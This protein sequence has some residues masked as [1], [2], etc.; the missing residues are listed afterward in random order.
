MR[1]YTQRFCH[2]LH[3]I[4]DISPAAIIAAFHANVRDPKMREKLSTRTVRSTAEL[5][6]LADKCARAEEGRLVPG[7]TLDGVEKPGKKS[8]KLQP[9][10]QALAVEPTAKKPKAAVAAAGKAG[11]PWCSIHNSTGHDLKD[12]RE[13]QSMAE[14][15]Q[16]AWKGAKK[17]GQGGE[18]EGCFTCG[19]PGHRARNCPNGAVPAE[20]VVAAATEEGVVVAAAVEPAVTALPGPATTTTATTTMSTQTRRR[21]RG[22]TKR[23]GM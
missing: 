5:F 20:A 12:C 4:P 19:K 11:S 15:R 6:A 3:T 8:R 13:V 9:A 22:N 23:P 14:A 7:E 1:K 10:K 21:K 17:G 18:L 16:K 2:V